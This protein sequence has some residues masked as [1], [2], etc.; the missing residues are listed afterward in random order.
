[1]AINKASLQSRIN[2][3]SKKTG[4]HQNILLKS[5]FF[6]AFL[7]RLSISKYASN[8]VFKGGFLL[9]TSLGINFR[10]TNDIDFLLKNIALEEEN[11]ISIMK[12]IASLN[13]GDN[14]KLSYKDFK[15]IREEDEYGGYKIIFE[16]RLENIKETI[17]IDIATGDP[18][19]PSDVDYKYKCL[20][21]N[22]ILDFKA[23]NFETIIAEKLQTILARG[24]LNSRLKDY[25]DLYIIHKLR[26]NEINSE[27]LNRA[28]INTCKYRNTIYNKE[29]AFQILESVMT[30]NKMN[31]L[32]TNYKNKNKFVGDVEFKETT[33]VIKLVLDIIFKN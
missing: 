23:Y 4:V 21:E 28:F 25:Y 1:M 27:I 8:F 22:Q 30:D 15:E 6:D 20:L 26:W 13:V 24:I 32:W 33:D 29:E 5:F 14:V 9:S 12:E 7:K 10:A 11:I 31:S 19:T 18:I 2:N 17:S 3:L 16:G